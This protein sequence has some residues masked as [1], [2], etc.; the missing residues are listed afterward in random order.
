ML[1]A[2][3]AL[4]RGYDE[5][6]PS[7]RPIMTESDPRSDA[8]RPISPDPRTEARSTPLSA[9]QVAEIGRRFMER[10][11]WNSE[12]GMKL[13][14]LFAGVAEMRVP[15]DPRFVG[16]PQSGVLHG[17]VV[18]AL[19][20]G[21]SG[22]AVMS[23]PTGAAGTSTLDLRID[24]MRPAKPGADIVARAECYKATRHVAFVRS[25]AHDG[26]IDDPIATAAGAFVLERPRPAAK[27][28]AAKPEDKA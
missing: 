26:D 14:S 16:D 19:L 6:A 24:Y 10:V 21:C 1:R 9:D 4:W 27:A 15:F 12:L 7:E 13:E 23:H 18:T 8:A 28:A 25:V 11:R 17:G 20:D 5:A 2:R 22:A 3:L